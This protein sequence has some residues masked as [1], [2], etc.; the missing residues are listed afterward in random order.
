M[1]ST[2]VALDEVLSQ[3]GVYLMKVD[4]FPVFFIAHF[5]ISCLIVREDSKDLGKFK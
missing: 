2:L 5:I 1:T 3:L 4:M